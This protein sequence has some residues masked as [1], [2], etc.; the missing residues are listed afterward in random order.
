M[1]KWEKLFGTGWARIL[2]P[3]LDSDEFKQIGQEIMKQRNEVDIYPAF[4]DLFRPFRECPWEKLS[5]VFLAV[6]PYSNGEGDG[7]LFSCKNLHNKSTT[8][9][10][11]SLIK[12]QDA[13]EESVGD[14][15]YLQREPDLA[16]IA[17]QGVLLLPLDLTTVQGKIGA[18]LDLWQPFIIAVLKAIREA[19]TG[20]IYVF[21][22]K[23]A[24]EYANWVNLDCN[25]VYYSEHP[26]E[27]VAKKR[28]WRHND[29]FF[30][31]NR[32]SKFLNNTEITWT[33]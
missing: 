6:N 12:F 24:K 20:I 18:H 19:N 3:F 11:W 4:D 23:K 5:V 1:N 33:T 29:M 25:D 31:I 32:V 14:G 28:P 17:N 30:T 8:V 16:L 26:M 9:Y 7:I 22:G 10:P 21:L 27:A 2:K 13:I 15:L